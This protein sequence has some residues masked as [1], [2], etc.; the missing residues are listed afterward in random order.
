MGKGT[1]DF[2]ALFLTAACEA[3][4]TSNQKFN[5]QKHKISESIEQN[6]SFLG[7][8]YLCF[9]EMNLHRVKQTDL[10]CKI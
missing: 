3:T 2:S 1:Q 7:V 6:V 4:I 5:F 9:Y 10:K 8:T